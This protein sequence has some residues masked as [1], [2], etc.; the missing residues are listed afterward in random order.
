MAG[1]TKVTI[2]ASSAIL[3]AIVSGTVEWETDADFGY[4]VASSIDG[5]PI[6]LLQP[7]RRYE[8]EGRIEEYDGIVA[9]L[10]DERRAYLNGYA[11][12]HPDIIA[13]I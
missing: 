9:R 1:S 3:E 2:D 11:G 4:E 10:T 5:V 8:R 7:R 13:S 6:D 12:L